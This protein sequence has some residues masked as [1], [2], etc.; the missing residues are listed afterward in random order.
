MPLTLTNHIKLIEYHTTQVLIHIQDKKY[1]RAYIELD[2]VKTHTT[3]AQELIKNNFS[4]T[5]L[6]LW[7]N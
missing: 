7:N 4:N 5:K 2:E 3:K 1:Y 6:H